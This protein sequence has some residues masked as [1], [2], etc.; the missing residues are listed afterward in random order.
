MY[1]DFYLMMRLHEPAECCRVEDIL[2]FSSKIRRGLGSGYLEERWQ[3]R[4][5]RCHRM[6]PREPAV[7]T[8]RDNG[9]GRAAAA[10]LWHLRRSSLI[11]VFT[12]KCA[13]YVYRTYIY[14]YI[15]DRLVYE[16]SRGRGLLSARSRIPREGIV[17]VF[18]SLAFI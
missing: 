17:R 4:A 2:G 7:F 10:G 6:T 11:N 8:S 9:K 3:N 15:L 1:L 12:R 5:S 16:A 18:V 14:V 13:T